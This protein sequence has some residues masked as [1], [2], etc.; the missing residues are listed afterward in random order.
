[1]LNFNL[2]AFSGLLLGLTS[3]ILLSILLKNAKNFT[4]Y[5]LAFFNIAVAIWGISCF[6]MR[7]E[8]GLENALSWIR[9]GHVGVI[10]IPIF[11][12][13]LVYRICNI[14]DKRF[15]VFSYVQGIIFLFL[16]PTNLFI[17]PQNIILVLNSFYYDRAHGFIYPF[18]FAVWLAIVIYGHCILLITYFRSSGFR[19][20]QILYLF[21]GMIVGFAGGVSN[22]F[23]VFGINIFPFGNFTITIYCII[24][25]YTIIKYRLLNITIAITRTGIF[26]VVYSLILGIPLVLAFGLHNYL[27][28]FFGLI[29]WI[30]PLIASTILGAAGPFLYLFIRRKAEDRLLREQKRY[31]ATLKQASVGMMRINDLKKLLNLI[32]YILARAVNLSHAYLY[33][34]DPKSRDYTLEAMRGEKALEKN[35]F[36]NK[37]SALINYL[38]KAK[39]P[40]VFEEIKQ[41][42]Q[43]YDSEELRKVQDDLIELKA[44]VAVPIFTERRLLAV[45]ILGNKKSG[46]MYT[47]DDLTV[48]SI[49]ANQVALAIENAQF[50]E[51]SKNTQQQLFQAEK[52]ATIGTMADGLSH[53]INNRLHTLGFIA[54]DAIDTIKLKKDVQD[55]HQF[56]EVLQEIERALAKIQDNV[57][58]GGEIVQ[59]LLRYTRKGQEGFAEVVFDKLIDDVI[60]MAQFK[61]KK[62]YVTIVK[63]YPSE[64]PLLHGNS[65]QLQEV[66]FNIIDNAYDAIMQKRTEIPDENF[67]GMIKISTRVKGKFLEVDV[68]D[69]GIG[70]KEDDHGKLFTPFFTTKASSRKGTGLGLYVIRKIV[71]DNHQGEILISS[72][73]KIGTLFVVRLP[74]AEKKG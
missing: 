56:Q 21:F 4:H 36:L 11:F 28:I 64:Q 46:A 22:F 48:F 18:F 26:I 8:M 25:T 10:F 32:V 42:S 16:V 35:F 54:G 39:V 15:L 23:P 66:F 12:L 55:P 43:D 57:R 19:R 61:I 49:L 1:M 63:E 59:G 38:G 29:W 27:L 62:E 65:T 17:S 6:F 5:I 3:L 33:L 70:V 45:G 44:A 30:V 74:V 37:R 47:A 72:D 9:I 58:Q 69:N 7:K 52:M 53:Q 51:E 71:E 31:Q 60:E 34:Y 67:K 50:Y 41:Q 68:V 13:H 20:N 24:L 40:I 2:F 14:Q 73:Y